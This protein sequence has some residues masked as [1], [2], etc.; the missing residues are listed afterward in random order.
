MRGRNSYSA[1]ATTNQLVNQGTSYAKRSVSQLR[2][3]QGFIQSIKDN[4]F[5]YGIKNAYNP[6]AHFQSVTANSHN[7]KGDASAIRPKLDSAQLNDLRKNH[8]NIGGPSAKVTNTSNFYALRPGTAVA[9]KDARP[10]LNKEA[11][12]NLCASHWAYHGGN[13]IDTQK[14]KRAGT[15]LQA[16]T[17]K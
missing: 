1:F 3:D 7:L 5:D 9:R 10:E 13:P 17:T 11:L 12:N 2:V 14:G 6:N 15:Q 8:F 4:H 16:H